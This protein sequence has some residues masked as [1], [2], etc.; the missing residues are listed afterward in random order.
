MAFL[1]RD[2]SVQPVFGTTIHPPSHFQMSVCVCLCL[3]DDGCCSI[4]QASTDHPKVPFRSCFGLNTH[5][6]P[7]SPVTIHLATRG[8][9]PSPC[10]FR[11]LQRRAGGAWPGSAGPG[12]RVRS[13]RLCSPRLPLSCPL[14]HRAAP[15]SIA[16]RR[17]QPWT[18][19]HFP[20]GKALTAGCPGKMRVRPGHESP[21]KTQSD[22][23]PFLS[24]P[25]RQRRNRQLVTHFF[26]FIWKSHPETLVNNK[27]IDSYQEY[28]KN[29]DMVL[30]LR[31]YPE[32]NKQTKRI[33]TTVF[34]TNAQENVLKGE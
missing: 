34:Q 10:S 6:P 25:S 12:Y 2:L 21:G 19:Y 31:P 22:P 26:Y 27:Y 33:I 15:P 14:P 17:A 3:N 8:K 23:A 28:I 11:S 20:P 30:S 1:L 32:P 5:I 16:S 13:R 4:A 7:L 24:S 9:S 18:V 29:K